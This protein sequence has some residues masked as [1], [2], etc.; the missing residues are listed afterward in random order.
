MKKSREDALK[1]LEGGFS[2]KSQD[3][4][5]PER[6]SYEKKIVA[7]IDILGI[8]EKIRDDKKYD[9]EAI[10]NIMN[11][12]H[13]FVE[14]SCDELIKTDLL[15]YV[16]IADGFMIVSSLDCY[17]DVCEI[18]CEIQWK[19]LVQL[20]MLAR[21]SITVGNVGVWE[22][23]NLI[24]GPAYVDAYMLESENALFSR[25]ILDNAFINEF[26]DVK[27]K[28]WVK[29]D[30][31][32]FYYLD[33]LQYIMIT[34]KKKPVNMEELFSRQGIEEFI[35]DG[36]RHKKYSVSQKYGWFISLMKMNKISTSKYTE[37]E[38]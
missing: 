33:F 23:E 20:K 9:A 7:W 14:H 19:I 38:A 4:I 11:T 22:N 37:R 2:K 16:Q 28:S 3:T 17:I 12:L 1:F 35:K 29:E 25:I 15:W 6:K 24:I 5:E 10:F 36:Y 31:D 27:E 34:E 30:M 13:S 21:G 8:R 26:E 32:K 18:L